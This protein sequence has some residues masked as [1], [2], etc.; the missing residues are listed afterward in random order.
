MFTHTTEK[1][2]KCPLCASYFKNEYHLRSHTLNKH[3]IRP[4]VECPTCQK[5]LKS[6]ANLKLHIAAAHPDTPHQFECYVCHKMCITELQLRRHMYIHVRGR[7]LLC[8]QCGKCFSDVHKLNRHLNRVDHQSGPSL[9]KPF[10][11]LEC[12]KEFFDRYKLQRHSKIHSDGAQFGCPMCGKHF[13]TKGNLRQHEKIHVPE[14][15]FCQ[16]CSH[17]CR[18]SGNLQKHMR[19]HTGR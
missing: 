11:C 13:K 3:T 9:I 7:S 10:S 5:T 2:T 16:Y 18:S 1:P 14:K 17:K 6:E 8:P 15:Y 12:G 19:V 4:H